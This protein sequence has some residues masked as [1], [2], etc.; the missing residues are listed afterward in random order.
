MSMQFSA[1]YHLAGF[2]VAAPLLC[3]KTHNK[4]KKIIFIT[5]TSTGFGKLMTQTLSKEGHTV[6]AAMRGVNAEC[7][8]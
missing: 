7:N 1:L 8:Q 5:G 3:K 6:I 4:M 2:V